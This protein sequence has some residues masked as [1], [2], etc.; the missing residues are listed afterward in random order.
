MA[1]ISVL[2]PVLAPATPSVTICGARPAPK[3]RMLVDRERPA[4]AAQYDCPSIS[5]PEPQWPGTRNPVT[6]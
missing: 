6:M 1:S 3:S 4:V 2:S 5:R